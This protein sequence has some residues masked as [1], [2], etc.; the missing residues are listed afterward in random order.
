MIRNTRQLCPCQVLT[1]P[2]PCDFSV[3]VEQAGHHSGRGEHLR[4]KAKKDTHAK[5]ANYHPKAS[6]FGITERKAKVLQS[7]GTQ[8]EPGRSVAPPGDRQ[9]HP[10]PPAVTQDGLQPPGRVTEAPPGRGA[11]RSALSRSPAPLPSRLRGRSVRTPQTPPP[12]RRE[13]R[14]SKMAPGGRPPPP[15]AQAFPP[16]AGGAS[17]AVPGRGSGGG[18][19]GARA[20]GA[21]ASPEQPGTCP[22]ARCA[23]LPPRGRSPWE[24][25]RRAEGAPGERRLLRLSRAEPGAAP[26]GPEGSD[27][28]RPPQPPAA[29]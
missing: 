25:P 20:A 21:G 5:I 2:D 28:D 16:P 23:P 1:A 19:G 27:M 10:P 4:R 11:P 18:A 14:R 8:A 15:S 7:A 24:A 13:L 6:T 3:G 26:R 29:S 9:G 22:A 17:P 12:P